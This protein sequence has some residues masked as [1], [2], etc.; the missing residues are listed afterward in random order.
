MSDPQLVWLGGFFIGVAVGFGIAQIV[1][2]VRALMQSGRR[3]SDS[4]P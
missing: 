3:R 4:G 1:N 2:A